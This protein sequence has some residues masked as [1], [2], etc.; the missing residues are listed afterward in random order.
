VEVGVELRPLAK[1]LD[2]RHHPR[3]KILLLR[4]RR[5]QLLDR[6][7]ASP[8]ECAQKL[9]VVQEVDPQHLGDREHP[10]GMAHLLHHLVLEESGQLG[11][12]LGS[13]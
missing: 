10:L 3:A 4:G 8:R 12:P 2:H 5:H 6:L 11:R 13:T 9:A 7:V 1:G